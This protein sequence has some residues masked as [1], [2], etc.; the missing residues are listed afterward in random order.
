MR[1]GHT[2]DDARRDVEC[3]SALHDF[4]SNRCIIRHLLLAAALRL[5]T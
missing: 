2:V 1:G 5:H 3:S 4:V